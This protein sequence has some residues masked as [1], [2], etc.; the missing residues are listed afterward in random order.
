MKHSSFSVTVHKRDWDDAV[1][2][3]GGY[4]ASLEYL[5]TSGQFHYRGLVNVVEGRE[6]MLQ[7]DLKQQCREDIVFSF[8]F[9]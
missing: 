4:Q 6:Q 9:I 3:A 7:R 5:A 1:E 2:I 8:E